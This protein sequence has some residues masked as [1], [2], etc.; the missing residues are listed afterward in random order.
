MSAHTE[1]SMTAPFSLTPGFSRV[2]LAWR[3]GNRFNGF[4][5]RIPKAAEAAAAIL[6]S[7]TRLKP[8]A[9]ENA[10]RSVGI[11][12]KVRANNQWNHAK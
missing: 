4:P 11:V 12:V 3:L 1:K 10:H 2:S 8:G 7:N 9:N 5:H 6:G